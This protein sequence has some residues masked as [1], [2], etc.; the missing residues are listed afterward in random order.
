MSNIDDAL[1]DALGLTQSI[2]QEILDPKPAPQTL[3]ATVSDR[4]EEVDIDYQ[5]S[6]ENFYSLVER[7]QDA[8]TGILDLAKES[9]HPR[10]YEVAGPVSYTHLRAHE[11]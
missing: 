8:I 5:Y 6:R 10:T 2:K 1:N 3:P 4:E 11:T 9:E 7:G